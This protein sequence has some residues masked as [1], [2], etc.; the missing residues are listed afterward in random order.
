MK[1]T[2]VET[3][4]VE[5]PLPSPIG[6]AIHAMHSV[7]CVLLELT[8]DAGVVGQSFVFTLNAVRI[9]A[10]DE[11]VR[12]M[13]HHVIGRDPHET[14]GIWHGIWADIN[15]TGH[16][17]VTISALSAI[18]IACWD[19]VGRAAELPLHKLFGACRDE[20]DTYA[21]SGLWLST[22][23]AELGA[24]AV[25]LV[26]KGFH[27]VKL[28]IG[29][30]RI[31][32]DVDRVRAVRDAIGNDIGLLVDANQGFTPKHAIR[33]GQ[34]LEEFDLVWIEEPVPAH[35][36]QGH[37]DV[38]AALATPVASGETEYTRYGMQA[39]LDARAADVLMPDLQRIGG[40]SEFRIAAAAAAARDV[41]VSSHFFTEHSLAIAGSIHNCI[42]VEHID[43]FAPLFNEEVELRS[44]KLV[45]PDRPGTGFTFRRQASTT[46]GS[47]HRSPR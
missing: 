8:T 47:P 7:G 35:D 4:L 19:A 38:R 46:S 5:L 30:Q 25:A 42:S 40:Y 39:M 21:S 9:R 32:D 22:P 13:S 43:W 2:G 15:P 12:G 23:T 20:V 44:G 27:A 6:T 34:R 10:F 29:S 11:M 37:S 31:S 26:E 28:R 17:G 45:I 14:S 1:I 18:D 33:L 16:K 24:E 36:L 41:P 3:Q